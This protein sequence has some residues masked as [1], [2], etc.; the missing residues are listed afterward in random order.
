MIGKAD[1]DRDEKSDERPEDETNIPND[2]PIPS[3]YP[4]EDAPPV[5]EPNRGPIPGSPKDI[6]V[7]EPNKN[8]RIRVLNLQ[9]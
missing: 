1:K 5:K 3:D 2:Y 4:D 7:K 8:P 6:P 9:A